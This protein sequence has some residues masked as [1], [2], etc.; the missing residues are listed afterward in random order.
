MSKSEKV[1]PAADIFHFNYNPFF[2]N[3]L[4]NMTT[5][6]KPYDLLFILARCADFL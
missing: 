5:Y 3:L 4:M 2:T 1:D 6:S